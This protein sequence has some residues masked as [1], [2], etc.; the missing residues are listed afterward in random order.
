MWLVVL[1]ADEF[2]VRLLNSLAVD[3][4]P[5]VGLVLPEICRALVVGLVGSTLLRL[6]CVDELGFLLLAELLQPQELLFVPLQRLD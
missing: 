5:D 6:D 2:L 3:L 1:F 4:L